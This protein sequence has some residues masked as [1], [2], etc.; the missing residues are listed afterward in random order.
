V[1]PDKNEVC[2]GNIHETGFKEIWNSEGYTD[3]RGRMRSGSPPPYCNGCVRAVNE[4]LS[5]S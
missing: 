2:F 5:T 4:G 1:C 3:L